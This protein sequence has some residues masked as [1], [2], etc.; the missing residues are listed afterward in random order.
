[1]LECTKPGTGCKDAP[2]AFNLKLAK[3]T[4]SDKLQMHPMAMDTE[5]EIQH[6]GQNLTAALGKHADYV[7][8]NGTPKNVQNIV[9]EVEKVFGKVTTRKKDEPYSDFVN[10]GVR[11]TR[12]QNGDM[13]MDQDEYILARVKF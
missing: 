7:K 12:M 2:G 9:D 3:V 11:H 4:R 1:M 6:D 13:V 10:C 8:I 5:L